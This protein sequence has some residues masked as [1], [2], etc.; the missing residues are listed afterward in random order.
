M[1][2]QDNL[3]VGIKNIYNSS[4]KILFECRS[5][6][7]STS[8]GIENFTYA[9]IRAISNKFPDVQII[10][11]IPAWSV[12]EYEEILNIR[13]KNNIKLIYNPLLKKI[14]SLHKY[15]FFKA[16]FFFLRKAIPYIQKIYD[17]TTRKWVAFT[18]SIADI[19][20]YPYHHD[21][22][23]HQKTPSIL[24]L[25]DFYDFEHNTPLELKRRSVSVYNLSKCSFVISC[26]PEPYSQLISR[27]PEN[28][29]NSM[30]IPFLMDRPDY[31]QYSNLS[32]ISRQLIYAGS[33]A[34]HKNHIKLIEALSILKKNGTEKVHVI[35][36]GRVHDNFSQLKEIIKR[37]DIEDWISFPGYIERE[38]LYKLYATSS[39]VVAPTTYEAFSGTVME[40][41]QAGIP[42][43]CSNIVQIRIFIDDF[44]KV[45][46][47]YFDPF[48]A[49][50]IANGILEVLDYSN[51]EFYQK[52]S[53]KAQY[54]LS[55]ITE[56]YTAEKYLEAIKK[57][58]K[59]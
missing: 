25:H 8:C 59:Y 37:N 30:M 45:K 26:W 46:V 5:I 51:Y 56:D 12:S 17:G 29:E 58:L 15:L 44:L 42:I 52:E 2:G 14:Y 33:T 54:F 34:K 22:I 1:I 38:E 20:I 57:V 39:A 19:V 43:T 3:K 32:K 31:L 55:E 53:I 10:C 27:F 4:M 7:P 28:K 13:N 23:L 18:D 40:G 6:T 49:E 36:P 16:V 48:N 50:D 24:V 47:R 11:S 41:F 21:K 9:I 35:C